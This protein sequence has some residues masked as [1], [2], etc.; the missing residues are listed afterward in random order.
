MRLVLEHTL[1]YKSSLYDVTNVNTERDVVALCGVVLSCRVPLFGNSWMPTQ[2][3]TP[4][5]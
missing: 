3:S 1:F 5:T 2:G 4:P